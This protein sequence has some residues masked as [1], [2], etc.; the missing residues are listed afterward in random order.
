[1]QGEED[2]EEE[3]EEEEEEEEEEDAAIY[4][5]P[6]VLTVEFAKTNLPLDL[7]PMV[8]VRVTPVLTATIVKTT[9]MTVR[10]LH[11]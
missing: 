5:V 9:S 10:Q 3:A 1:M 4:H 11:V 7:V 2:E 8:P 6:E